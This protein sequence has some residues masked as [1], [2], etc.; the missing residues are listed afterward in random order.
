MGKI[1]LSREHFT[2]EGAMAKL[3]VRISVSLDGFIEDRDGGM[4]WF[5]GSKAFDELLTRTLRG[6]DGSSLE[7]RHI[8]WAPPTGRPRARRPKRPKWP[9]WPTR[10]RS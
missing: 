8:S 9:K 6:I 7:A 5:A 1:A 3:F 2:T 10:S 4:D